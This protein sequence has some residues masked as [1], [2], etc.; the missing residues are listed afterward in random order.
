MIHPALVSR[1]PL[2]RVLAMPALV[3]AAM[4][5]WTA[6]WFQAAESTDHLIDGWRVREALAGRVFD[7]GE[8]RTSGYP[9]RLEV[10]C[11]ETRLAWAASPVPV[12]AYL[13]ETTFHARI[14]EPLTLN[15][16]FASP[17]TIRAAADRR[18]LRV[19]WRQ[20]HAVLAGSPASPQLM[21]LAFEA[22]SGQA[23][24]AGERQ[25]QFGA[26]HAEVRGRMV[27]GSATDNPV[28]ELALMLKGAQGGSLHS[29]AANPFDAEL[30]AVLRG[31][32]D[33]SPQPWPARL[34]ALQ[35]NGGR[36]ELTRMRF[37]QRDMIA[38]ATGML[39]LTD[40]GH[41]DGELRLTVAGI[42]HLFETLDLEKLLAQGLSAAQA[43]TGIRTGGINALLGAI[44]AYVPGLGNIAREQAS[45]G[46]KA[47][48]SFLGEKTTLDG[49][50]ALALPLR[51]VNGRIF[52]GPVEVGES[53]ALF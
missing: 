16:D 37:R 13:A 40:R 4:I 33:F 27:S 12:E 8:R 45:A 9:F 24:Q 43:A 53:P 49:E 7:C 18:G 34:R 35:A 30:T 38:E 48:L 11:R 50:P 41:L 17:L 10:K 52:L 21:A 32:K 39:A 28:V 44:D 36:I 2:W 19:A 51:F 14:S 1:R 42:E 3:A 47:G 46:V 20:G 31:L 5:G 15:A 22:V 29:L 25:L 26:D 23:E 6:V